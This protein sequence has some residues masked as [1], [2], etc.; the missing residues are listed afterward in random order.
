MSITDY[1]RHR[2]CD[3]KA[4]QFA[5]ERKRITRNDDGSIDSDLADQE[6]EENTEHARA[7]YGPKPPRERTSHRETHGE[8]GG[9]ARATAANLDDPRPGVNFHNARAAREI[10]EA[11][12]KKLSFEQKQGNLLPRAEVEA[13]TQN[14]FQVFREAMLNVP[15]RIAAQL[16]AESDPLKI[17]ELLESEI[18]TAL[19]EFAGASQ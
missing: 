18:R 13:A 17:H 19:Q 3:L 5:V 7:R 12:L 14:T 9:P 11:R 8:G 1:A 2:G 4:V 16:A 10:Y 15:N 6:W